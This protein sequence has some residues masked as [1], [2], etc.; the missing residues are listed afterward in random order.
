MADINTSGGGATLMP[1]VVDERQMRRDVTWKGVFWIAS[2]C[3]VY[4]LFTIGS[5]GA[6]A[7]G[8][9]WLV[10]I[11]SILMGILSVNDLAV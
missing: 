4:V 1:D 10:W 2:G 8:I 7:L 11:I 9:S 5:I 6:T 3:P